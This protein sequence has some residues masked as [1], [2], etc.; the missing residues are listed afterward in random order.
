MNCRF[1]GKQ[2]TLALGTYPEISIAKAR[3]RRDRA[4]ELLAEGL[5]SQCGEEGREAGDGDGD[6]CGEHV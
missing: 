5:G 2:K 1:A 3:R 6:G 4:G